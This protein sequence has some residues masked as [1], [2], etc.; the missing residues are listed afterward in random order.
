MNFKTLLI[1][2]LITVNITIKGQCSP[3]VSP[4]EIFPPNSVSTSTS[5]IGLQYLCGPNTILYDT[6]PTFCR[7]VYLDNTSTLFLKAL[8]PAEDWIFLKNN[9]T[10]NI[11]TGSSGIIQIIAEPGAIINHPTGSQ[12]YTSHTITCSNITYPSVSCSNNIT[13]NSKNEIYFKTWPNPA[14]NKINVNVINSEKELT[15]IYIKNQ[16]GENI[17]TIEGLNSE[18]KEISLENIPSGSYYIHIKT[19]TKYNFEKLTIIK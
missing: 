13:E 17:L 9:C 6:I 2:I 7:E 5:N 4:V 12:S 14:T 11:M 15:N 10:L 1:L 8:C 18:I 19:K 16:L 3:T